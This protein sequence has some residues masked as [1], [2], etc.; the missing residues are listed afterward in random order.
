MALRVNRVRAMSPWPYGHV[1]T[2]TGAEV[3]KARAAQAAASL[4]QSAPIEGA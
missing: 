4:A 3:W 1:T 2:E